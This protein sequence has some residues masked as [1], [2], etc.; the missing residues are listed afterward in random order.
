ML[1]RVVDEGDVRRGLRA[2]QAVADGPADLSADWLGVDGRVAVAEESGRLLEIDH[3]ARL[4]AAFRSVGIHQLIAVSNDPLLAEDLVYNLDAAKED[5][6]AFSDEFSGINAL[7]VPAHSVDVAVLCT[8]DDFH[9]VAGS[10]G[11]VLSYAGDAAVLRR[12][13]LAFDEG[14][15]EVM[16]PVLRRAARYM[17]WIGGSG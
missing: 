13:F 4:E 1:H 17:D 3:C 12:E 6:A 14:H 16:H 15:F 2:R 7:L 10:P 9:L 11:F 8:V 5:L